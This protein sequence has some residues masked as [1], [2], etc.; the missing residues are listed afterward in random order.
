MFS[1]AARLQMLRTL[2]AHLKNVRI[3]TFDG[4]MVEY[5]KSLEATC[6][7]RGIRAISDYEYELQMALMNRKLEPTLETVFM[8][9]AD[10][11]SYVSSRL[12]R[13]VAQAGGPVKG[14]VPEVV[15][16]KLREK[17]DL[18]YKFHDEMHAIKPAGVGGKEKEE[19]KESMTTAASQALKL[20]NRI[21]RIE[22][23][24]TMAVVAEADKLRAQGIDV[25]DF[26]AGEPHFSTPQHI[27][28]AAIAAIQG[29]FTKYTAVPGT[30]ELRDAIVHRHA[31]DFNSDYRREEAIASTGGKHALFNAI[32]VL[33]DHGDEVILPVPYWVSFKDIVRYAG[34]ECVLLQS[35]ESQG[36]R[37]TAEMVTAL[38]TPRT[39]VIILNSPSN[40]SGAVM[41]PK[42][43]TEVVRLAHE[44]G[45]WVLSDECYVYLNYTG[46]NFS[47]GSLRE[48]KERVVVLGS[49]SKTYAMTGWR[50][51]Y[52]LGPAAVVSAMAKLQSQST[53]NPTSIVQK[54]AVA[55][56]KGPQN[57]VEEMRREYIELRDHVVKGLRS[58]PGVTCTLPEGA[59]YTY[60][61]ISEFLGRGGVKSAS[62]V[63]GRLLREVH[64]ATVPGEGFGTGEHIRVSYATSKAEL[65][66]GLER[67]RKFFAGL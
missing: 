6:I 1:V 48:Y 29:N 51:G 28:D 63:A 26:G 32:Q 66:R 56:L 64:V 7:L 24:A 12:V 16:Q 37:V 17:L 19:E 61:N 9:P 38:I 25:V 4:L 60:P 5:A 33:V 44:R 20:T 2:T 34:G 43:L 35:D 8:M 65:D 52:A 49:L 23:S 55:A 67:M 53:S 14:L 62:E 27:K 50:L 54:A 45:I 3:D 13:E 11:Y 36:F 47:V 21:N 42:D 40:P 15:E 31:A 22:P 30:P 57:C 59:F 58:I 41:N 46:K 18:A 39:K 10:K